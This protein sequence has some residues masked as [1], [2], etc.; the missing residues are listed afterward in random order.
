[1]P[2]EVLMP[3][4]GATMEKGTI[5]EWLKNEGDPVEIGEPILEIMTDKIGMEVEASASGIL[6]K[7]LYEKDA[8]VPVMVPIAYIGEPGEKIEAKTVVDQ[9][10]QI[11]K[12]KKVIQH[13]E[14][15]QTGENL[16]Q[17]NNVDS[18]PRRTPAALKLARQHGI[19]LRKI[20]GSGPNNR[21]HVKDV[22]LFIQN[23]KKLT[24]LAKKIA[25]NTKVDTNS[26]PVS[27]NYKKVRKEDVIKEIPRNGARSVKYY[28]IRKIVGER[29]VQSIHTAPHVTLS[30][31]VDMTAAIDLRKRLIDKIQAITGYR[32]S[33]TEIIVKC[34]A[35]TLKAHPMLNA[36]LIGDQIE[37]HSD[38]NIGIAVAIPNGLIVPVIKNADQK[39]LALLTE[40]SKKM[41]KSARENTLTSEKLSG[42]TFTIS[43]LG[44]YEIDTFTPIINQPESAILGVGRIRDQVVSV[45]SSIEI[46]PQMTLSLSF[47]HRIIDGAPAAQFLTD[48]KE[49]LENP[50]ELMV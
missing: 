19:D 31:E 46:R 49:I 9:E 5:I 48:L 14:S 29:M 4:L 35:H 44:M 32:L 37:I 15:N 22:E 45:N 43:N 17:T 39:G 50:Y 25:E 28:G 40:E 30:T 33:F 8:E 7:K 6:L 13:E 27:L 3:K 26:I 11:K 36:S 24:P 12:D 18:K 23:S 21:I 16:Y 1:M 47:D 34:V 20:K 2:V 38:I 10:I 42:G 41:V